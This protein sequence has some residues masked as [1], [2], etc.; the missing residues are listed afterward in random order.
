MIL[1]VGPVGWAQ[2][3]SLCVCGQLVGPLGVGWSR[4]ASTGK[5]RLCSTWSPALWQP[6]LGLSVG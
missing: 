1:Q 4:A 5:A 2:L 6:R 3:G